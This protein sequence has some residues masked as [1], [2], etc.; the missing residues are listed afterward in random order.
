[1]L[2]LLA[3]QLVPVELKV[4]VGVPGRP[5][6]IR[7]RHLRP[8]Q[9]YWHDAFARAGGKACLLLG[10]PQ[11]DGSFL[12]YVQPDCRRVTLAPWMKG[13]SCRTLTVVTP[14]TSALDLDAW[15]RC[16]ALGQLRLAT[17]QPAGAK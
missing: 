13:W 17:E 5:G 7:P 15:K 1:M 3:G 12:C 16:M 14:L 2:L 6:R 8:V 4:G 10:M 11:G 9:I